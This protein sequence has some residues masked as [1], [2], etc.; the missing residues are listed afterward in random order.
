MAVEGFDRLLFFHVL[1]QVVVFDARVQLFDI[2]CGEDVWGRDRTDPRGLA[3]A[4]SRHHRCWPH[5]A[6]T[7]CR[8][9]AS[10]L[11]KAIALLE[12]S[13]IG[14]KRQALSG[15]KRCT[16]WEAVVDAIAEAHVG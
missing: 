4:G 5:R 14:S 12:I 15:R 9:Q 7:G 8:A 1:L 6:G 2:E 10:R 16:N 13:C 3:E 11:H